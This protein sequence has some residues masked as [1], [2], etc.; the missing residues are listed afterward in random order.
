M[1]FLDEANPESDSADSGPFYNKAPRTST[2]QGDAY[3][4][5]ALK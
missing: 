1:F 2:F 4:C 3:E 5:E